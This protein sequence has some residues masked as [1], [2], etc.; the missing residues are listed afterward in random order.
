MNCCCGK[1][2]G[3]Y[4]AKITDNQVILESKCCITTIL[5]SIDTIEF[6]V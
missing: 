4:I 1:I 2:D 5:C 3:Y 6:S